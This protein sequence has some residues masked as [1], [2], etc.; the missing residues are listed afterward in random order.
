MNNIGDLPLLT[1]SSPDTS[2]TTATS[3]RSED[4]K[5]AG[6]QPDDGGQGKLVASAAF[7]VAKK[8]EERRIVTEDHF[9]TVVWIVATAGEITRFPEDVNRQH[10]WTIQKN[11]RKDVMADQKTATTVLKKTELERILH[12]KMRK[13]A[14]KAM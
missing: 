14:E 6:I 9:R 7:L 8:K 13:I 1:G 3:S 2:E 11:S 4:F 10:T 5:V 12:R